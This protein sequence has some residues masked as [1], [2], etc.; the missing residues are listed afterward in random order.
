M[1]L[2]APASNLGSL[3]VLKSCRQRQLEAFYSAALSIFKVRRVAFLTVSSS[4]RRIRIAATLLTCRISCR[5]QIF[6]SRRL[7]PTDNTVYG[8]T[9]IIA[10]LG[11]PTTASFLV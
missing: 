1:T 3:G 9:R 8:A 2:R 11:L 4:L 5:S 7:F 6:V 10:H